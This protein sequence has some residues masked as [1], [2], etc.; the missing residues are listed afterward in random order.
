MEKRS[1]FTPYFLVILITVLSAGFGCSEEFFN[2]KA[3]ERITP[4]Q[5]YQSIKDVQVSFYGALIPLQDFM[6]KLIMLDGLRSDMMELTTNADGYFIDINNQSFHSG[7]PFIDPSDLYKVVININEILANIDNA[8]ERD[9]RNLDSLTLHYLKGGLV[10][11]RSWSYLT[12]S[13]LYGEVAYF[14]DNRMTSLPGSGLNQTIVQKEA[15][16]DTLIAQLLPYIQNTLVGTQYPEFYIPRYL[17]SK[18]LLGELYL[19]RNDYDLAAY[20]LK[21]ACESYGDKPNVLKVNNGYKNELWKNILT[22]SEGG[23]DIIYSTGIANSYKM[24]NLSVI[25]FSSREGQVN[26]LTQWMLLSDQYMVKPSQM[27]IDSFRNQALGANFG[28]KWRGEG[29][30]FNSTADSLNP[31]ISKYAA[32]EGEPYSTDIIVSRAADIHLLLAEAL[33]RSSNPAGRTLALSLVNDG[34]NAYKTKPKDYVRWGTNLGVRGR[35]GLK[36]RVIPAIMVDTDSVTIIEDLIMAERAMEL[37]FEGKRW[38]DLMRVAQRRGTPEYL[39]D[40]V[41]AKF[42]PADSIR[43]HDILMNEAN[44]YLPK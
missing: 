3:G 22:S 14:G 7:N 24:E 40:K 32:D 8:A 25:P 23:M 1:R 20:Y 35:V 30:T 9:T 6:P 4:E 13:R 11:L 44:W 29:I 5:H 33:N 36:N 19:E 15:M 28:D 38:F 39:A 10:A 17:N 12:I 31:Y 16:I 21:M 26:P 34:F 27:L 42:N 41:A 18:A 37:A 43:I 2:E